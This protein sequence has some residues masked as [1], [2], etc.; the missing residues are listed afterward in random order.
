[1]KRKAKKDAKGTIIFTQTPRRDLGW[2]CFYCWR[3]AAICRSKR[4]GCC[5]LCRGKRSH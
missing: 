3:T 5:P 2:P 1:M 4:L